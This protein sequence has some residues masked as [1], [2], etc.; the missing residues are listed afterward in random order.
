[1]RI[2]IICFFVLIIPLT[3]IAQGDGP[4][5][6]LLAP[7][8][9]SGINAKWLGMSSNVIPSGTAL[10][11]GADITADIFPITL[12]H[13]FSLAGR[14]AQVYGMMAPGNSDATARIGP[15]I[16]PIPTN[17][18]SASGFADGFLALKVGLHGAPAMN[19]IEFAQAPMQ[20]SLFGE[21]R[22]WYSGTYSA[23]DLFNL[24]TNRNTLQFGIPMAIPLN[25]NKGRATW[26]EVSPAVQFFTKNSDPARASSANEV[27]QEAVFI[28]ENHLSHNFSPKF[29]GVANLRFQYGGETKADGVGDGNTIK[30]MGGGVGIGYQIA[31]PLQV[32]AEYNGVLASS[33]LKG[34]MFRVSL[35][36]AYANVKKAENEMKNQAN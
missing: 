35:I 22:F 8:G 29:W 6:Y 10:I 4:R 13:T 15:P 20:F 2:L 30:A 7:K 27:S 18:I 23:D 1:M 26:L 32:V 28:L 34:N 12:F 9:V 17:S 3:G 31:T 24:G 33:E 19:L 36:F 5:S 21:F 25:T 14:F 16:G 11:P